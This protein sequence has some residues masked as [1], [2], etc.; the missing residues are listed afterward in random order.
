MCLNSYLLIYIY[1][2]SQIETEREG[3]RGRERTGEYMWKRG[4]GYEETRIRD[5]ETNT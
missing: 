1:P 2:Y 5:I 4:Q 3:G